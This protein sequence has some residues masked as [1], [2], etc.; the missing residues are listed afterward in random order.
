V[1]YSFVPTV[2]DEQGVRGM[3]YVDD[4]DPPHVHCFVGD[5]ELVV[6]FEPAV[7]VR[8]AHGRLTGAERRRVL[9][10]VRTNRGYLL[11]RW[12]EIHGR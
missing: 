11:R 5:G 2:L 3:L 1:V 9:D 7:A 12:R 8:E 6:A 4:H 10:L